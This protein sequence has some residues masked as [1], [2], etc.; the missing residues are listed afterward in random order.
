MSLQSAVSSMNLRVGTALPRMPEFIPA[1]L[2]P[3]VVNTD[4]A[5][6]R[7]DDDEM[8][9]RELYNFEGLLDLYRLIQETSVVLAKWFYTDLT[10]GV[11]NEELVMRGMVGSDALGAK[12]YGTPGS[13]DKGLGYGIRDTGKSVE[14]TFNMSGFSPYMYVSQIEEHGPDI[15]AVYRKFFPDSKLTLDWARDEDSST[16]A[17]GSLQGEETYSLNEVINMTANMSADIRAYSGGVSRV[18]ARRLLIK[19]WGN[20][21]FFDL[22]L[23]STVNLIDHPDRFSDNNAGKMAPNSQLNVKITERVRIQFPIEAAEWMTSVDDADDFSLLT[24]YNHLFPIEQRLLLDNQKYIIPEVSTRRYKA[25]FQRPIDKNLDAK[26][27]RTIRANVYRSSSPAATLRQLQDFARNVGSVPPRMNADGYT[28]RQN[29]SVIFTNYTPEIEAYREAETRAY[30]KNRGEFVMTPEALDEFRNKI[31]IIDWGGNIIAY[32]SDGGNLQ[33][34]DLKG[35]VALTDAD[36]GDHLVQERIP[37]SVVQTQFETDTRNFCQQLGIAYVPFN[38]RFVNENVKFNYL[39]YHETP[40]DESPEDADEKMSYADLVAF[41]SLMR[42]R[43]EMYKAL[44]Q[45]FDKLQMPVSK[46]MGYRYYVQLLGDY[47]TAEQQRKFTKAWSDQVHKYQDGVKPDNDLVVYNLD[48]LKT[49]YPHQRAIE[50]DFYTRMPENVLLGVSPGGG[51]TVIGSTIAT[52]SI[53]MKVAKR[54]LIIMPGG[55]KQQ[56]AGEVYRFSDH[57]MRVFPIYRDMWDRW[58][59][60][61]DLGFAEL[62]QIIESQPV[63]TIFIS[64][65]GFMKLRSMAVRVGHKVVTTYPFAVFMSRLFDMFIADESHKIKNLTSQLSE[66][67]A[68]F[69]AYAKRKVEMSG[70]V[71]FNNADD[72]V[73]QMSVFSPNMF[74]NNIMRYQSSAGIIS[75]DKMSAFHNRMTS[76]LKRYDA[77]KREWAFLLPKVIQQLHEVSM[78]QPMFEFY[79]DALE[80]TLRGLEEKARAMAAREGVALDDPSLDDRISAMAQTELTPLEIFVCAPDDEDNRYSQ[81]YSRTVAKGRKQLL[82]SPKVAMVDKL[83]DDHIRRGDGSKV[84]VLSYNK[85]ISKHIVKHSKYAGKML[86]YTA[87]GRSDIDFIDMFK[88]DSRYIA[89]V[90]D[91]NTLKEGYNLQVAGRVIRTQTVWTRGEFDQALSRVER[92]DEVMED[93]SLKYNRKNIFLDWIV[94]APSLEVAKTVRLFSK[95]IEAAKFENYGQ[96]RHFGDWISGKPVRGEKYVG[97]LPG[98]VPALMEATQ[99]RVTFS[100]DFVRENADFSKLKYHSELFD[101]Y[102]KWQYS[103]YDA[104]KEDLREDIAKELGV[105]ASQISDNRLR[106]A[107]SRPLKH[108][109][110]EGTEDA[111]IGNGYMPFLPGV[112][113]FDPWHLGLIEASKLTSTAQHS[114]DEEGDD[115]VDEEDAEE[116]IILEKGMIVFTEYGLGEVIPAGKQS[117]RVTVGNKEVRVAKTG[118]WVPAQPRDRDRLTRIYRA[119][120]KNKLPTTVLEIGNGK[121]LVN[122]IFVD[123]KSLTGFTPPAPRKLASLTLQPQ[124]EES[125]TT[126]KLPISDKIAQ[127]IQAGAGRPRVGIRVPV[128]TGRGSAGGSGSSGT[129]APPRIRVPAASGNVR[130]S[131]SDEPIKPPPIPVKRPPVRLPGMRV[132]NVQVAPEEKPRVPQVRKSAKIPTELHIAHINNSLCIIAYAEE[133]EALADHQFHRIGSSVSCEIKTWRGLD[134]M[135]TFLDNSFSIDPDSLAK[136]ESNLQMFKRNEHNLDKVVNN[137]S[138]QRTW[139]L[140]QTRPVPAAKQNYIFPYLVVLDDIV[141]LVICATT[142]K[143]NKAAAMKLVGHTPVPSGAGKFFKEDPFYIKFVRNLDEIDETMDALDPFIR[144]KNFNDLAD[145]YSAQKNNRRMR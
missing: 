79:S 64:D 109:E 128:V 86:H 136:L 138:T 97:S 21:I 46:R 67:F 34:E 12:A 62:Q 82:V 103:E 78:P 93:G 77:N 143:A 28:L 58:S 144:I 13:S 24:F 60:D 140:S 139:M 131:Q 39:G 141:H 101:L 5:R 9:M 129:V 119:M 56:F 20:A 89:M 91:E 92:P 84:L 6:S 116:Q 81:I 114:G 83:I 133:T 23:S 11:V 74:G 76:F 27:V 108:V 71:I 61:L 69:A 96:N 10:S 7:G 57:R 135:L 4:V 16:R 32:T 99:G 102:T 125:E 104:T 88:N 26:A 45:G 80:T 107:A 95:I 48:N 132:P 50:G 43:G 14:R 40:E 51:K 126:R 113:P 121:L 118:V 36:I 25:H 75:L 54:P 70:T 1:P 124:P 18:K 30:D 2:P 29:G 120:L 98:G 22:G 47:A 122:D 112:T 41:N 68:T 123:E 94:T 106:L 145:E 37:S 65:Y 52:K 3:P 110:I 115:Y 130:V 134:R 87:A 38:P 17:T 35:A 127:P 19:T 33:L 15:L 100:P 49:F 73:G 59:R 142:S 90:A 53:Q 137:I 42:A 55:L 111:S 8:A 63:N 85:A 105:P 117:V 66:A 44:W 72:T 31:L